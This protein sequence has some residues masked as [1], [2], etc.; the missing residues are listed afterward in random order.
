VNERIGHM[1]TYL[2]MCSMYRDHAEYLRE[3]IE[4]HRL[5]GV[6]RFFLYDNESTDDHREVLAPYEEAGVV[7]VHH[8]PTPESVERGVPWGLTAAFDDCLE[9]HREETRWL[10]FIDIDEFLFSP[11]GTA[12][13]ELLADYEAHPGVCVNRVDFGMSGHISKPPG[14]V[15]E[16]YVRRRR[17]GRHARA[18][19][20]SIVDPTRVERCRNSHWFEYRNGAVAVDENHE[21]VEDAPPHT[22]NAMSLSR[23]RINHYLV[24]SE[25]EYRTKYEKWETAL[26]KAGREITETNSWETLRG[27][28]SYLDREHD[29]VITMYVPRLREALGN[30]E[31]S[32]V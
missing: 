3:W 21:P 10:A 1:S 14:L 9:R 23:L 17:Y 19:V 20:K 12:L 22:R 32:A 5:V 31:S 29:D 6:E 2:S 28:V 4:F 11:T 27:L 7:V 15:I 16:N 25:E 24:K 18:H 8:W 26:T 30:A 13:P